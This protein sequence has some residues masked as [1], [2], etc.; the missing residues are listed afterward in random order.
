[1]LSTGA[2]I[3]RHFD[4]MICA[5]QFALGYGGSELRVAHGVDSGLLI[6]RPSVLVVEFLGC[7]VSLYATRNGVS[8]QVS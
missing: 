3:S 2:K 4:V 6:E 8:F 7:K 5:A 1:M